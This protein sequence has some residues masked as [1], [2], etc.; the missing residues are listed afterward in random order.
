LINRIAPVVSDDQKSDQFG[1]S[2]QGDQPA[3]ISAQAGDHLTAQMG[4]QLI[5]PGDQISDQ[6]S[7]QISGHLSGQTGGQT[8]RIVRS[9]KRSRSRLHIVK[10]DSSADTLERVT[11]VLK[12]NPE[13]SNRELAKLTKLSPATAKKY[14]DLSSAQ[15]E[16]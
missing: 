16:V 5:T 9:K 3:Q 13:C 8:K 10:N 1:R 4:D 7:D 2:N 11:R 14:R 6:K 12:N 15:S